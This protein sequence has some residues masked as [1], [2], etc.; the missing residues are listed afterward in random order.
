ML[1]KV[2]NIIMQILQEYI[3]VIKATKSLQENILQLVK[4][5]CGNM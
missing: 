2:Q 3:N 4:N 1:E 5:Y